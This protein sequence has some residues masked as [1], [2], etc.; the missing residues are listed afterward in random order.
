MDFRD[1]R[2]GYMFT[3]RYLNPECTEPFDFT[4]SVQEDVTLYAGEEISCLR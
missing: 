2:D 1:N 4:T 3:S